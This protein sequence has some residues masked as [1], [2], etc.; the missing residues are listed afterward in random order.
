MWNGNP[1]QSP[2]TNTQPQQVPQNDSRSELM[3]GSTVKPKPKFQV[4]DPAWKKM[5]GDSD[6]QEQYYLNL[7]QQSDGGALQR[8][9]QAA[10]NSENIGLATLDGLSS[11][12]EGLD[13]ID[14]NMESIHLQLDRGERQIK[15]I[16]LTGA[17]KNMVKG[18]TAH[19][20]NRAVYK[21]AHNQQDHTLE[22]DDS[23]AKRYNSP[24]FNRQQQQNTP[25]NAA[26]IIKNK[27]NEQ[28]AQLDQLSAKLANLQNIA[29]TA[30][31]EVKRQNAQLDKINH[32]TEQAIHRTHDASYKMQRLM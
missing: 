7:A 23:Y 18:D 5:E 10:S 6:A 3:S 20:Q 32:R 26:G 1:Q 31:N 9:L 12:A 13:R 8:A 22:I 2:T 28:D 14:T 27:L 19:K 30:G 4:N 24:T 16:G 25:T 21:M 29:G 11:Q 17:A 15:A